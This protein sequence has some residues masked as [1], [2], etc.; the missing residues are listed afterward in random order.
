MKHT[1]AGTR[2]ISSRSGACRV[3]IRS[4]AN[5]KGKGQRNRIMRTAGQGWVLGRAQAESG[6]A[7]PTLQ[8]YTSASG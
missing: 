2:A 8:L 5:T 4:I 6:R 7:L 1:T 3:R